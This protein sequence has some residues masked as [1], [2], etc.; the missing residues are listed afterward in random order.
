MSAEIAGLEDLYRE[1]ILDHYRDPHGSEP[2][3]LATV[4]AEGQNPLCGDE[5][6]LKLL[7]QDGRI[8]RI[9]SGPRGCSISVASA[10]MLAQLL[11]GRSLNDAVALKDAFQGVMHGGSWPQG[12][13]PG[14]LEVLE[15]VKKFPVR[16]KCALL[17]W[18]VLEQ[19]LADYDPELVGEISED[20][21]I[22]IQTHKAR[23]V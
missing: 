12:I 5:L 6:V 4:E 10:S 13:D 14:D 23:E 22:E 16:I 2:L 19:A 1:V 17:A 18:M 9:H 3:E 15:G 20:E 11:E 21:E 8:D 7:I